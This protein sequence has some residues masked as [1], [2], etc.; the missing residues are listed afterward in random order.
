M[1]K[2]SSTTLEVSIEKI[3]FTKR[4]TFKLP[5]REQFVEKMI[6]LKA[7]KKIPKGSEILQLPPFLDEKG[8]DCAENR[9]GKSRLDFNAKHPIL[10]HWKHQVVDIFSRNK[11][12]DS[13][14]EG[15]EY[16][17]NILQ[18]KMRILGIQNAL[19][20]VKNKCVICRKSGGQTVEPVMNNL[21]KKNG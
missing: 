3:E 15:T 18:Q 17:T 5:E 21:C 1:G 4:S 8:F 10:L 9:I 14:H 13:Q 19:R 7:E 12:K 20:A 11:H 6:S 2:Y 16:V